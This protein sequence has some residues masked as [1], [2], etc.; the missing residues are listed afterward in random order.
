MK[1]GGLFS[2]CTC[3][4]VTSNP[5]RRSR[6]GRLELNLGGRERSGRNSSSHGGLAM[7]GGESTP[8]SSVQGLGATVRIT[9]GTGELWG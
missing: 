8:A 3:E 1:I 4:R 7:D 5:G 9:E 2:K 6:D